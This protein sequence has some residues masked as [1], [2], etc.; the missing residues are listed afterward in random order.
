[1]KV[2]PT[3]AAFAVSAL[4][5]MGCNS[6]NDD[7]SQH[8]QPD[9]I[10]STDAI[11]DVRIGAFNL[12]FDRNSFSDLVTEMS[13]NQAQQDALMR[14]WFD[15]SL[16]DED[17]TL[18]E[19]VIQIRNVAAIIQ[20]K[21]PAVL[22]M[23]EFNNDGIA[24][25]SQAIDNFQRN[26]LS[27]PQNALGAT[28][29]KYKA[30]EPIEFG[31]FENFATNTGLLSGYDLNHD[32]KIALPADA[33][34]FGVY[35]GQYA[36]SLA[37]QFPI[38]TDNIRTFQHFKWKDMPGETNPVISNCQDKKYP[39]PAGKACGDKWYSDAAWAEKPMSSKNHVDAPIIIP[40]ANG[41]KVVH[42]LMSHPTPPFFD[43]VTENN[44]RLNR[45]EI[46]FWHDYISGS[47]S[48]IYD[49]QGQTGGINNE[50]SFV[51][52]GDLNADPH[53]GDGY[54]DTIKDLMDSKQVNQDVTH[55]NKAPH[56]LGGPECFSTSECRKNNRDI[57]YSANITSTSGLRL[58]HVIPSSDLNVSGSGVFW[59]TVSE[60]GHLMMKDPRVG[61][62]GG[63]G[64][65]VSSDHRLVWIDIKL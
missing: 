3:A 22:L 5:L 12:S 39:I 41:D 64:K 13:L 10:K 59:P 58:D 61:K 2:L 51:I 36:F 25:D 11:K 32:G 56:S 17:K 9:V 62:W 63:G 20:T 57:N 14:K 4:L 40:T 15:K 34:G 37:S 21:R 31:F 42:L 7:F 33:W 19:K 38:D 49:D 60:Q 50:A 53:S 43:T 18:A 45:A 52:L 55:G 26:Y 29:D 44:K 6:N 27:V 24:D 54:L 28:A 30:L 1:M 46:K 23:S 48:Y 8:T 16:T 47:G 35:H 65:S